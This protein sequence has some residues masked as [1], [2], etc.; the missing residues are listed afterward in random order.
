[1]VVGMLLDM[2]LKDRRV[3]DC[4]CGTGILSIVASKLGASDVVGYDIDEWSVRNS[5]HNATLNQVDNLTVLEGN[6]SVLSHVSG[7]FDV[8]VA[9]I[10]RNILVEDMPHF[11]DVMQQHAHLIISG[12]YEEDAPIL[13]ERAREFQL[14]LVSQQES[15]HW[16]C[17]HFQ[18][19]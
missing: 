1:M 13:I 9:N 18:R 5:Q 11:A 16:M 15:D 17:L 3:L 10:N 7:L 6:S 4:G 2:E 8:V 19:E 14:H 12:F